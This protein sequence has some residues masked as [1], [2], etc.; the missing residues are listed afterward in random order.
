[1]KDNKKVGGM[2]LWKALPVSQS[3]AIREALFA[4][5]F[6]NTE[7]FVER[8][9]AAP[10]PCPIARGTM[11]LLQFVACIFRSSIAC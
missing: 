6:C 3:Q 1:M 2:P 5:D 7:P 10:T 8:L 11:L 4:H 9:S